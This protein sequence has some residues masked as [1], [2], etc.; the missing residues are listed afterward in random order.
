VAF[1]AIASA[2]A[3]LPLTGLFWRATS[4]VAGEAPDLIPSRGG[5]VLLAAGRLAMALMRAE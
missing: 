1:C 4:S 2:T 3:K 5:R